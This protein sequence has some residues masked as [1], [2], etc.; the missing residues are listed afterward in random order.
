LPNNPRSP[1]DTVRNHH[2][3]GTVREQGTSQPMPGVTVLVKG[4]T[5]GVSTDANGRYSLLVLNAPQAK[6]VFSSVGYKTVERAVG[7]RGQ[8]P[9]SGLRKPPA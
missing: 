4:T 2:V 3:R 6:L 5:D 8:L 7:P 1:Q 9:P